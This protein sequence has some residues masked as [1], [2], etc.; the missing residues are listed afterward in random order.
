MAAQATAG[1]PDPVVTANIYCSGRL[2][3]VI[4]GALGPFWREFRRVEDSRLFYLWFVRYGKGGEH[5]KVRL[6]GPEHQSDAARRLLAQAV[7]DLFAVLAERPEGEPRRSRSDAPPIDVEDEVAE[8]RP[9]RSLLWTK[10]RRSHV[11]LGGKPFLLEDDYASL[12]TACLGCGCELA[13]SALVPGESGEVPFR[14]RQ[15]ALLKAL[16]VGVATLGFSRRQRTAYFAYHRDWLLRFS[17][18]N[19][20]QGDPERVRALEEQFDARASRMGRSLD[21][22][23]TVAGTQWAV[24]AP[25]GEQDGKEVAWRAALSAFLLYVTPRCREPEYHLDPFAVDPVF[26]PVFK[27]FHG[28]ANQLGLP[29]LDEALAHHLLLRADGGD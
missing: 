13:L 3:G 2:D 16:I 29:M 15:S 4:H 22:L 14:Q 27:V 8:D 28:V 23:R 1:F 11:S 19:K 7:D 24:Q 5:V 6:H 18:L 25:V 21:Q 9:D 20:N 10:Y 26:S 12:F 17:T